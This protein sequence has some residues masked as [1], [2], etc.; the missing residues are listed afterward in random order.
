MSG[1][2][3][4]A[5]LRITGKDGTG[6]AFAGVLKHAEEL[7]KM[8]GGMQ[9]MRIGGADFAAANR[10]IKEQTSLLRSERVAAQEVNRAFAAGNAALVERGGLISRLH[11][12]WQGVA[13]AGGMGWMIGGLASGR[14]A[15]S[16]AH[17]T[18]EFEHQKALLPA[19]GMS[20]SEIERAVKQAWSLS[21]PTMSASENLKAT[22]ELRSVFGTTEHAIDHLAAVQ[23][24]TAS[25]KAM[26][27]QLDASNESYNLARALEI[28]G[29]SNDPEHFTRLANMM[30]QA[31]NATR[32]KVTGSEFFEFTKYAR[33]GANRLSDDFYTRIAPTLIQELGGHSAGMALA[34]FRQTLVGG[35]MTNKAAEEMVKLGLIN[36]HSVI[37]TKTGSV[38]GVRPGGLVGADEASE[39]PDQWI[40]KYLEPALQKHGITD[41]N[42]ISEELAHLF[43][44][45]FSEQMASILLN[46]QQRISKDRGLI[47]GAP[48]TDALDALRHNDPTM[49][50]NDFSA[51]FNNLLA[52]FGGPLIHPA[53]WA[54]NHLADGA[55]GAAEFYAT[56]AKNNPMVAEGLSGAGVAGLGAVAFMGLKSMFGMFTG[57][58]ALKGSA[59]ALNQ[60]AAALNAAAARLGSGVPGIKQSVPASVLGGAASFIPGGIA[61]MTALQFMQEAE[62]KAGKLPGV[63]WAEWGHNKFGGADDRDFLRPGNAGAFSLDDIQK[64]VTVGG[65]AEINTKVTVEPSP[66][67][68]TR[69]ETMISN[70]IKGVR[71]N[72][73]TSSTG[74][75]MPEAE[76]WQP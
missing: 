36:P 31:I 62:D 14:A 75:S 72:G 27:P 13:Q 18:V 39:N 59:L 22:G 35:K 4:E 57:G 28:K 15:R 64:A 12:R 67:F 48:G 8:L 38:K 24:A 30:V 2:I 54:M 29:V 20:P 7:K 21:V 19:T 33:G 44:N 45:R 71:I 41:P 60:S 16:I 50:M 6:A 9:G 40:K 63:S 70:G 68:M 73:T 25:M 76:S 74:R 66:D 17:D 51:G 46:Q 43:S 53:V 11:Q 42:R 69:I 55:R 61:A 1:K 52:A 65:S 34:S 49:A 23:R 32:G 47:E 58:N 37:R 56:L 3:L 26:N 10:A 5:E